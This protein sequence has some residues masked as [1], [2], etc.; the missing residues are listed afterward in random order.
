MKQL[1][2]IYMN[3]RMNYHAYPST[4]RYQ[5]FSYKKYYTMVLVLYYQ[6]LKRYQYRTMVLLIF[7]YIFNPFII[8]FYRQNEYGLLFR[9]ILTY[10]NI[11]NVIFIL[12][13]RNNIITLKGTSTVLWY[14]LYFSIYVTLLLLI[15]IDR[16]NMA[17]Y[18]DIF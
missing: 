16:K 10:F 9:H 4:V 1:I 7:L 17:Y 8:Q 15:F 3:R 13:I 5:Y 2:Y 12:Y 18:S 6:Y 11:F 14:Y